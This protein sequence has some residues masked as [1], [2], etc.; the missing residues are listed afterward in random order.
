VRASKRT[1][2]IA[3]HGVPGDVIRRQPELCVVPGLLTSHVVQLPFVAHPL[4]P[5][6]ISK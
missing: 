6:A 3:R 4:T 5:K 1:I 2:V